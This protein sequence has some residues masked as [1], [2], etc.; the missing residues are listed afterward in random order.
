MPLQGAARLYSYSSTL[1][2]GLSQIINLSTGILRVFATLGRGTIS[3]V[4]S[5]RPSAWNYSAPTGRIFVK[6]GIWVFC[7]NL[8]RKFKFHEN[9]TRTTGTLHED[10]R[11]LMIASPWIL[12]RTRS[13]SKKKVVIVSKINMESVFLE[14]NNVFY[15][16][17]RYICRCQKFEKKIT[18]SCKGSHIS[19][20]W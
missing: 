19:V 20:R 9:M 6:F 10:L 5:V 1:R 4:I 16:L 3:F 2:K 11:T 15:L 13:V 17:L 14:H 12:L 8:F 18:S 7:E